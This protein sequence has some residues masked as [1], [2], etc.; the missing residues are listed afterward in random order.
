VKREITLIAGISRFGQKF[1]L[2]VVGCLCLSANG[3]FGGR[4][5]SIAFVFL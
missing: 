1:T 2:A 4:K 5:S 3:G